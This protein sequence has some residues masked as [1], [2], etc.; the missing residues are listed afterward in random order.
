MHRVKYF[1]FSYLALIGLAIVA[2]GIARLT[3]PP[4]DPYTLY[5]VYA[6]AIRSLDPPQIYDVVSADIGGHVYET[7]YNYRYGGGPDEIIPQLAAGLPEVSE[8]GTVYTFRLRPGVHF[9]DPTRRVWPDG[10]GPEVTADDVVFSWKRFADFRMAAGAYS[11]FFQGNIVGL[12]EFRAYTERASH[13]GQPVDL[14]TPVEGLTAVDRYTVRVKLTKPVPQFV[15][16]TASIPTAIVS[17]EA[18]EKLGGLQEVAIGT[19]PYAITEYRNE[20]RIVME[21]NPLYRGRPDVDPGT[22]V[23][24][25]DRLPRIRR[26]QWDYMLE[27]LP[28]WY[29]FLQGRYD[30]TGIPKET[31]SDVVLPDRTLNPAFEKRGI[32]LRVRPDMGLF[33]I[34]FNMTDPVVGKNLPLRQAIS[35]GFDRETYIRVYRNGRGIPGTGILPPDAPL[36][37]E[38]YRGPWSRFDPELARQKVAEATRL[39]GGPLP[40]LR[41]LLG[42]TDTDTRQSAEF[43]VRQ[44]QAIG[45]RVEPDYNTFARYLEK[46]DTKNFQMA[47]AGWY[48]DYPDEKTYLKLFDARLTEPPGSNSSGF[49]DEAFQSR[50]LRSEIMPRSPERDR[51]YLEMRDIIDEQLPAVV[52]FYPQVYAL[53]YFWVDGL[54]PPNFTAGFIAHYKLDTEA[55]RQALTGR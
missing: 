54:E 37:D 41:L 33:Y 1:F 39:H 47:W 11:S 43:F 19:G 20:Q 14:D 5:T 35:L 55:R 13:A 51:L 36:F 2:A 48:P 15:L 45:L 6:D 9:Y 25:E 40:P 50:L 34:L 52:L 38:N 32:R 53:R 7:L 24:P 16:Y 49:V 8:D 26:V 46:L 27:S 44:M 23:A 30:T 21:A 18:V 31:F 4:R 42:G 17:R 12:D 22:E 29:L 28:V 3:S 10:K